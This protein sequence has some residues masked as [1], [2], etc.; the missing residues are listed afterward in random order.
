MRILGRTY[1][2]AATSSVAVLYGLSAQAQAADAGTRADDSKSDRTSVIETVV[3][4]AQKRLERVLDVPATVTALSGADLVQTH[5]DRF[6]DWLTRVPGVSFN[7]IRPGN[8]QPVIRGIATGSNSSTTGIYIDETPYGSSTGYSDAGIETPDLDPADLQRV[9]VLSG[10]QGTLYGANSLGG[11]IKYVTTPPDPTSFAARASAEY[12]STDGG[13]EGDAFRGMVNVPLIQDELSLRASAYQRE[14]P[15]YINNPVLGERNDNGA[16]VKGVRAALRWQPTDNLTID[17]TYLVQ[18]LHSNNQNVEDV[19]QD[20]RPIYGADIERRYANEIG[21]NENRV[22]SLTVSYD[23]GW[24]KLLGVSSYDTLSADDHADQNNGPAPASLDAAF[25]ATDLGGYYGTMTHTERETDE[26]RL[27]SPT[28][29]FIEWQG[30]FYFDHQRNNQFQSFVPININTGVVQTNLPAIEDS[31]L[32]ARYTEYAGYGDVRVNVTDKFD[33]LVGGRYGTNNQ[34]FSLIGTGVAQVNSNLTRTSSDS[35]FTWLINPRYKFDDDLMVYARIASGYNPGGP[36]PVVPGA[37]GAV[38]V[39]FGPETIVSYEAG[40]KQTLLDGKLNYSFD[41]FWINWSDIQL[42]TTVFVNNL[43]YFVLENGGQAVSKG[44]ELSANYTP[45]DGLTLNG[46]LGYVDARLTADA[47]GIGGLTGD[48]LARVPQVNAAVGATYSWLIGSDWRPFVGANWRFNGDELTDYSTVST[49][50]QLPSYNVLDLRAGVDYD[51]YDL[52]IF[53]KNI[54]NS[55][56]ITFLQV[57]NPNYPGS[58]D[59][60]SLIQP[61]TYGVN[62]TVSY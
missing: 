40:I 34:N 35:S 25:G 13:G 33:V 5:A 24:A 57:I 49:R 15:G 6:E 53:A 26:V 27:E 32:L 31:L 22:A 20:L 45:F 59:A 50:V 60:A 38:P 46:S 9:E 42:G 12:E 21:K 16:F 18:D 61:T 1:L 56:G 14:D 11:L 23:F 62:I 43:S 2:L 54:N 47:P 30:G 4:T 51:R 44:V 29:Q 55:R 8:T 28:G 52:S 41:G 10:P 7:S 37:P 17:A 3:V 58:Y 39:A 36:N 48:R 19:T